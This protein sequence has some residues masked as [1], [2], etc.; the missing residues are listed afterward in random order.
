L[1]DYDFDT[2]DGAFTFDGKALFFRVID[3]HEPSMEIVTSSKP[4]NEELVFCTI[5]I[6]EVK[7]LL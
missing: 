3:I 2:I 7:S 6:D 4:T 1:P 5:T